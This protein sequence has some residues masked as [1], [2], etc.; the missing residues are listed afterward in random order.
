MQPGDM[1]A[2]GTISGTEP[3]SYG[4]MLELCWQGT[5]EV[6]PLS[7]GSMRKFLK[8]GDTVTLRG[9]CRHAAG[10]TVGFGEC[11]GQLLPAGTPPPPVP[12]PPMP[13][14]HDVRLLSYWRSSCSWRVRIALAFYHI[15][16]K[17]V[18]VNLLEG[19]QRSV[20]EMGQVPRLDW[21]DAAGAEVSLTQ[22]L[23][24]IEM[25]ADL[26]DGVGKRSLRPVDLTQRARA[27]Q[28][29]EIFN[30]GTQPLQNLSHIKEMQGPHAPN[31]STSRRARALQ[32]S[33]HAIVCSPRVLRWPSRWTG[34]RPTDVIDGRAIAKA[35]I[36]RGCAAAEAILGRRTDG[37]TRYCVGSSLSIADCCLV[38][39]LYNARRFG[40]DLEA[41][42]A[43]CPSPNPSPAQP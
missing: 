18:A 17:Y 21:K 22:S 32:T 12:P 40:V 38:P 8:D 34:E 11:A 36:V 31:T 15:R 33:R 42:C 2:S 14:V 9:A 29:A 24:I 28:I 20:S 25:L 16:Y 39:Q 23:P 26:C 4:S 19:A 10:Y 6:G 3:G 37:E 30:A 7:D 13:A 43:H 27:R 1:L 5:K 41:V 35:A